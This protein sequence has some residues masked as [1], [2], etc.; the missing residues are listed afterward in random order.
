MKTGGK[1]S[2]VMRVIM[3]ILIAMAATLALTERNSQQTIAKTQASACSGCPGR[4]RCG[5]PQD[6]GKMTLSYDS[7]DTAINGKR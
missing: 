3:I 6:T 7:S 2:I 1:V 4:S 5:L